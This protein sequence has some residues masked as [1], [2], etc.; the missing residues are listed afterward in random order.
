MGR[1]RDKAEIEWNAAA[2]VVAALGADRAEQRD[3]GGEQLRDFD[4]VFSDGHAEPLEVTLDAQ[5]A[6]MQTWD[7]LDRANELDAD[8]S[9]L[10]LISP[11]FYDKDGRASVLDVRAV[12]DTLIPALQKL[13]RL[14]IHECETFRLWFDPSL[15][16]TAKLL[17][18]YGVHRGSSIEVPPEHDEVSR[19][20]LVSTRGGAVDSSLITGV[21]EAHAAKPDNQAKL[22]ACS[23]AARRH[24]HVGLTSAGD[25]AG[26]PWWA[27]ND[28]LER[29]GEM[30]PIPV[31]PEAIT[32][33]WAGTGTG[34]IYVTPP[35]E[36]CTFHA[37]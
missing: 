18:R 37:S 36:W 15:G 23:E 21:L 29:G 34:A 33:M 6:V 24:L 14:A 2:V 30:P 8:L 22:A 10:W 20:H 17:S 3:M 13:E 28:I 27:L 4:I 32:T 7:R 31:L 11:D 26:M 25:A 19:L 12:R 9:R 35:A 5:E 1:I 16:P